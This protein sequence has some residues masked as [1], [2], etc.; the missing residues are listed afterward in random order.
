ME[1]TNTK[2]SQRPKYNRKIGHCFLYFVFFV[3]VATLL[4][5]LINTLEN[6]STVIEDEEI[7]ANLTEQEPERRPQKTLRK[8]CSTDEDC[9]DLQTANSAL[10]WNFYAYVDAGVGSKA[11]SLNYSLFRKVDALAFAFAETNQTHS[12]PLDI[13]W[14]ST[15]CYFPGVD[16]ACRILTMRELKALWEG[17]A[18]NTT[19]QVSPTSNVTLSN[20]NGRKWTEDL[21]LSI[22]KRS[23]NSSF[24]LYCGQTHSSTSKNAA[25]EPF[26]WRRVPLLETPSDQVSIQTKYLIDE[27]QQW[28]ALFFPEPNA[29]GSFFEQQEVDWESCTRLPQDTLPTCFLFELDRHSQNESVALPSGP[30]QCDGLRWEGSERLLVGGETCLAP[31]LYVYSTEAPNRYRECDLAS[32]TCSCT[33]PGSLVYPTWYY[34]GLNFNNQAKGLKGPDCSL[35]LCWENDEERDRCDYTYSFCQTRGTRWHAECTC[36]NGFRAGPFE[37]NDEG[38]YACRDEKECS[39]GD[40]EFCAYN[41]GFARRQDWSW[42]ATEHTNCSEVSR[43]GAGMKPL[44]KP[45]PPEI[46][47]LAFALWEGYEDTCATSKEGSPQWPKGDQENFDLVF[48]TNRCQMSAYPLQRETR[49][50]DASCFYE[51]LVYFN[52]TDRRYLGRDDLIFNRLWGWPNTLHS[53]LGDCELYFNVSTRQLYLDDE[54]SHKSCAVAVYASVLE[55]RGAV[56]TEEYGGFSCSDTCPGVSERDARG[57]C[58]CPAFKAQPLRQRGFYRGKSIILESS[59]SVWT[60]SSA[61]DKSLYKNQQ[62]IDCSQAHKISREYLE[63]N[64]F[65]GICVDQCLGSMC[66]GLNIGV[67]KEENSECYLSCERIWSY[68]GAWTLENATNLG[69]SKVQAYSLGYDPVCTTPVEGASSASP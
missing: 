19:V 27:D 31:Q 54:E 65:W 22:T 7:I 4:V 66:V 17:G 23:H 42:V 14:T 25:V 18:Q 43:E 53:R 69:W 68:Y 16:L 6:S 61:H 48:G 47:T 12:N 34:N 37:T 57:D 5:T 33:V 13:Q 62:L 26:F 35:D 46:K 58:V 20:P 64:G 55:N 60:Q 21:L 2:K 1:A 9:I 45:L 15:A 59:T 24:Y 39:D 3:G 52:G 32:G 49:A 36:L 41:E 51:P 63:E 44:G 11:F 67:R 50:L 56:C 28:L 29:S 40:L 8:N 38:T 30:W 10:E